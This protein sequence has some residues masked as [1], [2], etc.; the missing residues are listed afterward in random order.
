MSTQ[1]H[2]AVKTISNTP[3]E[4][5]R[6]KPLAALLAGLAFTASPYVFAVEANGDGSNPDSAV[7]A[8]EPVAAEEPVPAEDEP[9]PADEPVAAEA[10]DSAAAVTAAADDNV[11]VTELG[12]V[13]V[14]VRNR[15]ENLQDVPLSI[16]VVQGNELQRLQ[17]VD[18]GSIT[19]RAANV[20][21]NQGNQRTSS[22]A[23][24]S[25]GKVG[26]T[27]A[28]DPSV[29]ISVDGVSYAYNP[30][31]S[32]FDFTD[33]EAVEVTRGPQGTLQGKNASVG[34][35]NITTRRPSFTESGEWALSYGEQDTLR[36]RY[37]SG[38]PVVDDLLA[39]RA[40]ISFA[41]G[42][43][44]LKNEF[45]PDNT[46]QNVDRVSGRIQFLLTPT[47]DFSARLA[48]D[49]QPT[50]GENTNRRVFNTPTPTKYSN[51]NRAP[52]T[53]SDPRTRLNRSWFLQQDAYRYSDWLAEEVNNDSQQP[54]TTSSHGAS[55]EL[56]WTEEAYEVTSITAFKDYTFNAHNNDEGT[57]FDIQSSSGQEIYYDQ[58]SQEIRL[59]AQPATW[60]DYQVG[61]FLMQTQTDIRRNVI[62]GGD[63]GAW[64]AT[65]GQYTSLSADAA[66][67]LLL[68]NSLSGVWKEENLQAV[69]NESASVFGQANWKP[70]DPLTIT[71][72]IRLTK[73]LRKNPGSSL[74]KDYG[75]G[76]ELNPFTAGKVTL[77]GVRLADTAVA[78]PNNPSTIVA[79]VG[80]LAVD[81]V[82]LAPLNTIEQ[83]NS[84]DFIAQKY[85][86]VAPTGTPGAAYASLSSAQKQQ[87]R[88]AQAL[89]RSQFGVL[90]N[91][92]EPE[93]FD[94]VLPAFV[95]SP[96]Y[97]VN[98]NLTTYISWQYGE[99]AGISQQ[100]FGNSA[101]ADAEET[102]AWE[103]G[104][105][106]TSLNNTLVLNADIFY[107]TVENYQAS[108]QAYDEYNTTL[109]NDGTT[110]YTAL[111]GNVPEVE[112]SGLEF[113][114]YYAGIPNTTL[115]FSGAYT[116]A[117]YKEF[118]NL[119]LAPDL[120]PAEFANPY[121]DVSGE[122]LPGA[123]RWSFNV[124]PDF[125]LPVSLGAF[126]RKI[127]H[128]SANWAFQSSQNT[129]TTLSAYGE[130]PSNSIWDLSAGIGT[131]DEKF[132]VSIIVKNAFNNDVP[133]LQ[134]W[135][136]YTPAIPRWIGVEFSGKL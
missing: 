47:D 100:V 34:L 72:G 41:Q 18:L 99:K 130:I 42:E 12:K 60:V 132:D 80:D 76:K 90:W 129:D 16:S 71:T 103:I 77:G 91:F 53:N 125:R 13:T 50:A 107:S 73:E 58:I 123:P 75:Y 48:L 127:F 49:A 96:S 5:F 110:Y 15:I 28:Q 108:V 21:W 1:K 89:R 97:K 51:S 38:G 26:Q 135:N 31:S 37:A 87:V 86:G 102:G 23:I 120:D 92:S 54:V 62:Y 95:V 4:T 8:E 119:G 113:D 93:E 65:P 55:V 85:F 69:D 52:S 56:K 124:G 59:N 24:R 6:L 46:Y 45:N 81:P 11:P 33:V 121:R 25:L 131:V 74:I 117:I 63:A 20:S 126:G 101:L 109:R 43:G 64:F 79:G 118:P 122:D 57:P 70:T 66:G 84:A 44:D 27:E 78:D 128:T 68:Q 35:I 39:Y 115:R 94:D 30:L 7:V 116:K 104:V 22:V 3:Q 32:S 106:T 61:A 82:T 83:L 10:N 114:G 133:L 40:A 136:T 19:K 2:R 9:V 111:T 98:D 14:R 36:G 88:H 29:G 134:T 112:V 17:A 105:K 67:R